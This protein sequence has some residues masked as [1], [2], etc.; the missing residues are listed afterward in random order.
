MNSASVWAEREPNFCKVFSIAD[1]FPMKRNLKNHE[2]ALLLAF[3]K[4]LYSQRGKIFFLATGF[5]FIRLENLVANTCIHS[6]NYN[7]RSI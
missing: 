1:I 5:L 7:P 4:L 2:L 3:S 6:T